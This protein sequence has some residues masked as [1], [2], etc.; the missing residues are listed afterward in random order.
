MM[1][2][3]HFQEPLLHASVS[4]DPSDIILRSWIAAQLLSIIL[5]LKYYYWLVFIIINL[6]LQ[7][8]ILFLN[9]LLNRKLKTAFSK[10]TYFIT[11]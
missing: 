2:K 4:H 9:F 1:A 5:V 3:L 7:T 6:I 8:M 10:N 11:L